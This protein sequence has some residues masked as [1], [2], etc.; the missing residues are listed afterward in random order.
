MAIDL[1]NYKPNTNIPV[2]DYNMNDVIF[3][4]FI[5]NI[6]TESDE[7]NILNIY[8]EYINTYKDYLSKYKIEVNNFVYLNLLK[9]N[10]YR[11]LQY[12]QILYN[13][14][15]LLKINIDIIVKTISLIIEKIIFE[16]YYDK[17]KYKKYINIIYWENRILKALKYNIYKT[18][19][20]VHEPIYN[21]T[22]NI[23][24]NNTFRYYL[25]NCKLN[26]F[27]NNVFNTTNNQ[28]GNINNI[29]NEIISYK[30]NKYKIIETI[31]KG[32][33]GFIYKIKKIYDYD[34]PIIS[35]INYKWCETNINNI[36][37]IYALKIFKIK[38]NIISPMIINEICLNEIF[39]HKNISK[40]YDICEINN[41]PAI[42][43]PYYGISIYELTK[44]FYFN[45]N[46]IKPILKQL[47]EGVN[48][49]HKYGIIHR[50]LSSK[51]I[52]I[53]NIDTNIG[54]V[55]DINNTNINNT[56]INNTNINNI[57]I[58]NNEINNDNMEIINNT[59]IINNKVTIIDFG[60][61]KIAN[62]NKIYDYN[63]YTMPYR[64]PEII[65]NN[66]YSNKID[67]WAVGCILGEM[68]LNNLLLFMLDEN[69]QENINII[70]KFIG[71]PISFIN[72]N[73]K[74]INI[75][76]Y[77]SSINHFIE[78]YEDP[79][80]TDL[81]IKL[82]EFDPKKRIDAETAL[83]HPYFNN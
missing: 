10:I 62:A 3:I 57:N 69:D 80:L 34:K 58:N 64:A 20:I 29:N 24:Y 82:L 78:C 19:Y 16:K 53:N 14:T 26:N 33:Y 11:Y 9:K 63:I 28:A 75:K 8:I 2:I 18:T 67:I 39:K 4:H 83:K 66:E 40:I 76:N 61:S 36:N 51:N 30:K 77:T 15:E 7:Q 70:F 41:Q 56:N 13:N 65:L 59:E 81:F 37:N 31:D 47:L 60:L 38:D 49:L 68:L 21:Y 32:S 17:N 1:Y 54:D 6:I 73:N 23:I 43:F 79:H 22:V 55:T 72:N 42:I 74:I 45:I 27:F 71:T 35:N 12:E 5:R 46:N 48:Y 52:L 50:D 25:N 44:K